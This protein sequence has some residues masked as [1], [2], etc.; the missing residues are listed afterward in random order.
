M[1]KKIGV[2]GGGL[3]M[4]GGNSLNE[5]NGV[6]TILPILVILINLAMNGAL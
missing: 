6:A 2:K 1:Y 3:E 4:N 5:D